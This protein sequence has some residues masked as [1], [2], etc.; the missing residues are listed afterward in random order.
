MM[1]CLFILRFSTNCNSIFG[2]SGVSQP[3][4]PAFLS[5][6]R[7]SPRGQQLRLRQPPERDALLADDHEDAV[8]AC[9]A[10]LAGVAGWHDFDLVLP[11]GWARPSAPLGEELEFASECE[12]GRHLLPR[13]AEGIQQSA[14]VDGDIECRRVVSFH[15]VCTG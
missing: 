6:A 3:C 2:V 5:S 11:E 1:V 4:Q 15:G 13:E 10:P 7:G 9:A 12:V 8:P 14:A